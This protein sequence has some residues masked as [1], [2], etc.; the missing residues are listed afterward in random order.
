VTARS[1][2]SPGAARLTSLGLSGLSRA[3]SEAGPA[4]VACLRARLTPQ[5]RPA[6][7]LLR[8]LAGESAA[9]A[10]L[11]VA[12]APHYRSAPAIAGGGSMLKKDCKYYDLV[13]VTYPDTGKTVWYAFCQYYKRR[14]S[15]M[16]AKDLCA[17]NCPL[18]EPT[19]VEKRRPR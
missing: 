2:R 12:A 7:E 6:G 17:S 15:R 13:S 16:Q 4:V 9:I 5:A 8:W 1:L 11:V 18:Y 19:G 10:A 14:E 3:D